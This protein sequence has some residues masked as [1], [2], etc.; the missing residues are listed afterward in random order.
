MGG[1]YPGVYAILLFTLKDGMQH[2]IWKS[3][4]DVREHFANPALSFH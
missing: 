4:S 2:D 1:S 3:P